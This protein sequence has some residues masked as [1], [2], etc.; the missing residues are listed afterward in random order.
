VVSVANVNLL[1]HSLGSFVIEVVQLVSTICQ[2]AKF[3]F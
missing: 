2:D 1:F 3:V